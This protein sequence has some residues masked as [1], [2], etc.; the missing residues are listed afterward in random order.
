[1]KNSIVQSDAR[2][3]RRLCTVREFCEQNPQFK[4]PT[5]RKAIFHAPANG[6]DRVVVRFGRKVYLD[7]DAFQ[8]WL[9]SSQGE[10]KEVRH[11]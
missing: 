7:I 1:V 6:F 3:S 9:L 4:E 10:R 11:G 5:I 8:E 2:L